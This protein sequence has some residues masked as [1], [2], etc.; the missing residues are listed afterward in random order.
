MRKANYHVEI[1]ERWIPYVNRRKDFMG[2]ADLLCF[3]HNEPGVLA[4]Q[5]TTASHSSDH[6]K[7]ILE[8]VIINAALRA[9]ITAGNRFLFH[10]WSKKGKRG[11]RKIWCLREVPVTESD[12]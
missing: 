3:R 5:A 12:I 6:W 11:K 9:W 2:F 10:L 4:I 1:V 8:N 7:K